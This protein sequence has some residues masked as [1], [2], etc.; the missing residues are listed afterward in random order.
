MKYKPARQEGS[1]KQAKIKNQES[2]FQKYRQGLDRIKTKTKGVVSVSTI[3][4]LSEN[5][6]RIKVQ[7]SD[8]YT[9]QQLGVYIHGNLKHTK[10]IMGVADGL[11]NYYE[12]GYTRIT[13]DTRQSDDVGKMWTGITH[14]AYTEIQ[15]RLR[16]DKW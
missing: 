7:L 6:H 2:E 9:Y 4:W 1:Q 5:R 11:N 8:G 10:R 12:E 13:R 14:N 3:N 16:S 15:L